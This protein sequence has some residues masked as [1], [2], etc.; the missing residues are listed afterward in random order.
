MLVRNELHS[1]VDDLQCETE[2]LQQNQS[3]WK[4]TEAEYREEIIQLNAKLQDNEENTGKLAVN[5]SE[6]M[7]VI[8]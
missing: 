7:Q 2:Q 5:N 4:Q 6:L 8:I 1:Q 3:L